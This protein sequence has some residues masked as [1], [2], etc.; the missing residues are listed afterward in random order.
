MHPLIVLP[1][2]TDKNR[3]QQ[4]EGLVQQRRSRHARTRQHQHRG[5]EHAPRLKATRCASREGPGL[6]PSSL[7][8][9]SCQPWGMGLASAS[10]PL[11]PC[12]AGCWEQ[13]ASRVQAA[14]PRP[15]GMGAAQGGSGSRQQGGLGGAGHTQQRARRGREH[16]SSLQA[17]FL[18]SGDV[19]QS[20]ATSSKPPT[21][22]PHLHTCVG[23]LEGPQRGWGGIASETDWTA[24][25]QARVSSPSCPMPGTQPAGCLGQG[26]RELSTGQGG[27][28]V[29]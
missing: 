28:H 2:R 29:P 23:V 26:G 22:P 7:Q 3:S 25:S 4:A 8:P 27:G 14:Q 19:R 24:Q 5:C 9:S 11:P 15:G 20:L 13:G 1:L 17:P 18:A 12:F 6:G 16:H 10:T 21:F